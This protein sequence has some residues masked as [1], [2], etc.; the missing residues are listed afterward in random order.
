[1]FAAL[2]YSHVMFSIYYNF[3]IRGCDLYIKNVYRNLKFCTA[4]QKKKNYTTMTKS[5]LSF[6][7]LPQL[8]TDL[9]LIHILSSD[10][11]VSFS[12]TVNSLPSVRLCIILTPCKN[13]H[14]NNEHCTCYM[15][16]VNKNA[17][18]RKLVLSGRH[19]C[20]TKFLKFIHSLTL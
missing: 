2:T 9:D 19:S 16:K 14:K 17:Q 4:I 6:G 7:R 20:C 13:E 10:F 12:L 8:R 3:R 1:M 15:Y 18:K 11:F 5:H